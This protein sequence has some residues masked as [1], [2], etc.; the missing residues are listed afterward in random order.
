VLPSPVP[1]WAWED[2]DRSGY[3]DS[4]GISVGVPRRGR[5]GARWSRIVLLAVAALVVGTGLGLGGSWLSAMLTDADP[6]DPVNT[7][8]IYTGPLPTNLPFGSLDPTLA[9]AITALVVRGDDIELSWTDPSGGVASFVIYRTGSPPQAELQVLPGF[10]S[11]VLRH[12]DPQAQQYC[13]Y[14]VAV[15]FANGAFGGSPVRCTQR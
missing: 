14:V 8:P 12:L 13:F 10:T 11:A 6:V 2:P 5:S 9:P 3:D 4:V 7:V 1:D 15:D